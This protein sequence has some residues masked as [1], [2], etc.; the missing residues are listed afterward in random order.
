MQQGASLHAEQALAL[1]ITE[2]RNEHHG[3]MNN[4]NTLYPYSLKNTAHC[5]CC[6]NT[7]FM[8]GY[9][10]GRMLSHGYSTEDACI[11]LQGSQSHS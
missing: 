5:D 7:C 1:E 3:R 6:I 10:Q 4:K 11:L 8:L 2:V 9:I